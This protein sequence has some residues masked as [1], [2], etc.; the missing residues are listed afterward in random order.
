MLERMLPGGMNS[1]TFNFVSAKCDFII[2]H[3]GEIVVTSQS[4]K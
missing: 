4:F 2:K 3:E 1:V